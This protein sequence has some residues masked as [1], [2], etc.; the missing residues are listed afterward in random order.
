LIELKLLLNRSE[1]SKSEIKQLVTS[2]KKRIIYLL[3]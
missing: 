3:V 2:P 1:T